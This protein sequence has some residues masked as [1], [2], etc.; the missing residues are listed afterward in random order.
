MPTGTEER[1]I[2]AIRLGDVLQE[3]FRLVAVLGEGGMSTVY[4]AVEQPGG[5]QVAVKVLSQAALEDPNAVARFEREANALRELAH[6]R[7][8]RLLH[9]GRHQDRPF[10]VMERVPGQTLGGLIEAQGP[11]ALPAL[12]VVL[13]DVAAA[14]DALHTRGFLHRD[15]KSTNII[16]SPDGHATL[17]D[18]G[19]LRSQAEGLTR[20]GAI[21]GTPH[22]MSPE[23]ALGLSD[24]DHRADIYA[25]GVVAF[26]AL[27]GTRPF[28]GENELFVIQQHAHTPAPNVT[29]RAARVPQ[30]ASNVVARALTKRREDRYSSA[31]EFARAFADAV[32][33]NVAPPSVSDGTSPDWRKRAPDSSPPSAPRPST[34]AP[35]ASPGVVSPGASATP[36]TVIPQR[37]FVPAAIFIATFALSLGALTLG[38]T[39]LSPRAAS[40]LVASAYP[41]DVRPPV[42]PDV[43]PPGGGPVEPPNGNTGPL[44]PN[45]RPPDEKLGIGTLRVITLRNGEPF[46]AQVRVDGEARGHSPVELKLPAGAHVVELVRQGVPSVSRP[47]RIQKGRAEI[48]KVDLPP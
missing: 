46:W 1:P 8:V 40:T 22:Y 2:V 37:R 5:A 39:V 18:L 9:V 47:V 21:V 15:V 42:V 36:P 16:V 17:L 12:S 34:P 10:L 31:G 3:R 7:L 25:V 11:L 30:A 32:S 29:E 41:I 26:E 33:G 4:E 19:I 45:P 43:V 23:Q 48:L 38:K 6:P 35:L 20:T 24:V 44:P 28:D 14:L 13:T 27:T